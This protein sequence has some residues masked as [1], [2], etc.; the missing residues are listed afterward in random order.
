[1]KRCCAGCFQHPWL[2]SFIRSADRERGVCSFCGCHGPLI[3]VADLH[4]YFDN[5]LSIY[6]PQIPGETVLPWSDP[7]DDGD[8]LW[9]LFDDDWGVFSERLLGAEKAG[10]LVTAVMRTGWDDDGELPV[11][12]DDL[13]TRRQSIWHTPLDEA[14]N[15]FCRAVMLDPDEELEFQSDIQEDLDRVATT[16]PAGSVF[17]RARPGCRWGAD[18][19]PQPFQGAEIGAPPIE[20]RKPK[21]ANT[22]H[23]DVLYC[24]DVTR[25]AVAE[26]KPSNATLVSACRVELLRDMR[27]ADLGRPR[28][29]CN[30]FTTSNLKWE[31]EFQCL[32]NAFSRELSSP[33]APDDDPACYW[34]CQRLSALIR[35]GGYQ[36]ILYPSSV[37]R[38]GKNL[39][40]FDPSAA[41]IGTSRL[42]FVQDATSASYERVPGRLSG[43]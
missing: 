5:A 34:P 18:G 21:R 41:R 29:W 30:P 42:L 25:T 3:S 13:Y 40:L 9:C 35:E 12:G 28:Y 38:P 1:M 11:H 31:F 33:I 4:P 36:G 22:I 8:L 23:D 24:A 43:K 7:L 17:Y 15:G 26:I 32:L 16:L 37:R 10:V 6:T 2:R 27:V 39:V 19:L 20:C 14:W